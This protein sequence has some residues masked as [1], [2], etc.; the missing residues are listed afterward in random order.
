MLVLASL[1]FMAV[2]WSGH[3]SP[4][5]HTP[6]RTP[7]DH[8]IRSISSREPFDASSLFDEHEISIRYCQ[9]KYTKLI[10]IDEKAQARHNH[11]PIREII[12]FE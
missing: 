3:P 1:V 6:L 8:V 10:T 7:L 12:I 9:P 2:I 5:A 11:N 4:Y